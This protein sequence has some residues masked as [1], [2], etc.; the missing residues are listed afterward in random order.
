MPQDSN[1]CD[2]NIQEQNLALK[3]EQI[4]INMAKFIFKELKGKAEVKPMIGKLELC[5]NVRLEFM[6]TI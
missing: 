5:I 4:A 6:Y 2:K 3:I 1:V